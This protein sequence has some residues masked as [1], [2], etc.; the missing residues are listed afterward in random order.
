[1]SFVNVEPER[2]TGWLVKPGDAQSLSSAMAEAVETGSL[3]Q[4]RGR[5]ARL[6]VTREYSWDRISDRVVGVYEDAISRR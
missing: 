5:N 6:Y 4:T 2:E 1:M 3:R